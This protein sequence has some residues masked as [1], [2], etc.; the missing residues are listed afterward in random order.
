MLV[1]TRREG[2]AV[3]VGEAIRIVLVRIQGGQARLAIEAPREVPI[4]REEL[5]CSA[6][7]ATALSVR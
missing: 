5:V 3:Q 2:E 4:W 6:A 7:E 1:L